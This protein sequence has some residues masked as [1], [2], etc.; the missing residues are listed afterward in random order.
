MELGRLERAGVV[1]PEKLAVII[2][3]EPPLS[4]VSGLLLRLPSPI[5]ELVTFHVV[6]NVNMVVDVPKHTRVLV[7]DGSP[8]PVATV[9]AFFIEHFLFVRSSVP[10]GVP[11]SHD[12]HGV[13]FTNRDPIVHW[14]DHPRQVQVVDED[15]GLVHPPIPVRIDESFDSSVA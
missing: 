13:G 5:G 2:V 14:Q 6:G 8:G 7:L 4:P 3:G 12:V 11:V 15:G 9:G 10:V 1:D